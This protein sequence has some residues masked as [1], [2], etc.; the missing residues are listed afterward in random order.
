MTTRRWR[1]SRAGILALSGLA[2]LLPLSA[3]ATVHTQ[4]VDTIRTVRFSPESD[5]RAQRAMQPFYGMPLTP[6][7]RRTA[8][9]RLMAVLASEQGEWTVDTSG[10]LDKNGVWVVALAPPA[11]SAMPRTRPPVDRPE[12]VPRSR[13]VTSG[14]PLP[15]S[16]DRWRHSTSRALIVRDDRMLWL[17]TPDGV[18]AYPVAVGRRGHATPV[19]TRTVLAVTPNPAWY[20]TPAMHRD[21]AKRGESLPRRVPPGPSNPLGSHF[22][23]LGQSIGIHGTNAPD[24]IGRAVSRGC[25]R[26]HPRDI[27]TVAA[28][29]QIGDDVWIVDSLSRAEI[30]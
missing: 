24:S 4:Q 5:T 18:R 10:A 22:I 11:A 16:L 20:P 28:T 15:A 9:Q 14:R 12:T 1:G 3:A 8:R 21:A 29:L 17:K 25:I 30:G 26:M 27:L 13:R 2:F 7:V 6:M 19:G 23:A